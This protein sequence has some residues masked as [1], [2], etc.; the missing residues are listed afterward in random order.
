MSKQANRPGIAENIFCFLEDSEPCPN[1]GKT[2][3]TCIHGIDRGK[4]TA[5]TFIAVC[6]E[7]IGITADIVFTEDEALGWTD[8]LLVSLDENS[9]E[10]AWNETKAYAETIRAQLNIALPI[11]FSSTRFK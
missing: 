8:S 3:Q 2:C 4:I 7:E 5:N 10:E 1:R 11:R 9:S 6:D